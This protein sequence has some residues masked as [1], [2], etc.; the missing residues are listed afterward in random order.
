MKKIITIVVLLTMISILS[1]SQND[2]Y[3]FLRQ[4]KLQDGY[5][6]F[7]DVENL[8][9]EFVADQIVSDLL[10]L[11][12]I[13]RADYFKIRNGKDRFHIFCNES[14]D[15]NIIYSIISNYN[16]EYDL[17][18]VIKNGEIQKNKEEIIR[19]NSLRSKPFSAKISGFPKYQDTGDKILDNNNY[20][21]KKSK[22]VEENPEEYNKLI[23]ELK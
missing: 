5:T 13:H 2:T 15:A 22:W 18:T 3:E 21:A 6:T 10:K 1:F 16:V 9:D 12:S 14:M 11:E 4:R 20:D 19:L 23:E 7:F 8:P 17:S